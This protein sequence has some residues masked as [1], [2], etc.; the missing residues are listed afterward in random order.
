MALCLARDGE[1]QNFSI[2]ETPTN[3]Q[4]VW[5]AQYLIDGETFTVA[6]KDGSVRK[7]LGYPTREIENTIRKGR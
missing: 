2:L 5:G 6:T 7:I 4:I 1:R 3:F